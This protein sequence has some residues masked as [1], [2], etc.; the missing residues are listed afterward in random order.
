MPLSWYA[1]SIES[2]IRYKYAFEIIDWKEHQKW[3]SIDIW[4]DLSPKLRNRTNEL[5]DLRHARLI[6]SEIRHFQNKE[7]QIR[8]ARADERHHQ[9]C[10]DLDQA[11]GNLIQAAN[12][13]ANPWLNRVRPAKTQTGHYEHCWECNKVY[14]PR[15]H[16]CQHQDRHRLSKQLGWSHL[17]E[18]HHFH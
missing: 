18:N 9:V 1:H 10:W 16:Y 8:C 6:I 17:A 13:W 7:L 5:P 12:R 15:L 14:Q 11:E 3:P 2:N 4:V